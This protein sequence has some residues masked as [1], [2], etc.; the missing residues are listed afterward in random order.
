MGA[1]VWGWVRVLSDMGTSARVLKC[2]GGCT[3]AE[4]C[5]GDGYVLCSNMGT[6]ARKCVLRYGD[7]VYVEMW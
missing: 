2:G 6:G 1:E 4:M 7:G 3:C 5:H